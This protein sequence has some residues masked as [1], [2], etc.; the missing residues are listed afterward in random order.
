MFMCAVVRK[1]KVREMLCDRYGVFQKVGLGGRCRRVCDRRGGGTL[2]VE[3][4]SK[5]EEAL[6]GVNLGDE[7]SL[8]TENHGCGVCANRG[9]Q[10]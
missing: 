4:K 2:R 7:L 8:Y 10:I 6:Q 5:A 9:W 3:A 1:M